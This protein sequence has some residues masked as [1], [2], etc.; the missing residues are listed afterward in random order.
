M[1]RQLI[2]MVLAGL[3]VVPVYGQHPPLDKNWEVVFQDDFNT[4]NTDRWLIAN[5]FDHYGGEAQVYRTQNVYINNG[6]LI[7]ETKEEP[8]CCPPDSNLECERQNMT[9]ECY[10][11]TSGWIESRV[12]YKYGYFEIY[13]KLPGSDG[14][15]PAFW[16]HGQGVDLL[17]NECWYNEIDVFEISG[18]ITD[19]FDIGYHCDYGCPG[20][21]KGGET[22]GGKIAC[23]YAS[24]YHWYGIEW[25]RDKITWYVDRK[26]VRRRNNIN[27]LKDIG[28][29]NA[30]RIIINTA[31][32][33]PTE[34][35]PITSNSIFPNYM[36]VDTV[37]VY[38]LKCDGKP[39]VEIPDYNT[40]KYGVK[41]SISL[42]GVSSLSTGE[43]VSLR[44]TDFIELTNGFEV[45]L[46][47]ELYL[48]VNP[49]E[50]KL[51]KIRE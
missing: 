34:D 18:C 47:A 25:D 9:G 32:Q 10:Q 31:L 13:A 12:R 8:Y 35:C 17:T 27:E 49:C 45:P 23:N 14:Y 1:K 48:D 15:W 5:N 22:T 19:T 24:D 43:D 50:L 46:G 7:L 39:V 33:S 26:S 3:F 36:Y 38:R 20:E 44:A 6:K 11:Y 30:I 41:K 40:F 28:I 16:L 2:I 42:S 4:F 29:W 37:N 51:N 21:P